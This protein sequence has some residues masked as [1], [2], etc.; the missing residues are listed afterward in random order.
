MAKPKLEDIEN[1]LSEGKNF[2]LSRKQYYLLTGLDI[3]QSKSY[4]EKRSAVAKMAKEFGY[5]VKF[6]PEKLE[7][8]KVSNE[9]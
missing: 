3:P 5:E 8:R 2:D 4:T 6:I 7:F 9:K 1:K